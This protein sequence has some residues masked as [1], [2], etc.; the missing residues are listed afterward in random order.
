VRRLPI[1]RAGDQGFLTIQY[2]LA[3]GLS[4]LL[5]VQVANLLVVAYGRGAVRAA[6]DEG[7]RA[8]AVAGD[9]GQCHARA[10]AVLGDLLAGAMRAGVGPIAC[11]VG[12]D[13]V[14]A[15]V[16]TI[17]AAWIPGLPAHAFTT[18]AVAVREPVP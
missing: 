13:R 5:L 15:R 4:L 11:T 17:L 14:R 6:L 9:P 8:A 10:E 3:V 7:V 1:H 2:T 12:T 18:E 16:D